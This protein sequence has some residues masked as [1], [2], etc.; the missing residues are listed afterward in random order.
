LAAI[1][2]WNLRSLNILLDLVSTFGN[3]CAGGFRLVGLIMTIS[4]Q[5]IYA[6]LSLAGMV[7]LGVIPAFFT[8][9]AIERINA[10]RAAISREEIAAKYTP[11]QLEDMG[12][13]SPLYRLSA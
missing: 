1:S 2:T 10:K 7:C 3:V 13:T 5:H 9:R 12:D 11:K 4:S 8:I 6:G